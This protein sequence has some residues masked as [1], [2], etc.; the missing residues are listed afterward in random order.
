MVHL[1]R[2]MANELL[3]L[4]IYFESTLQLRDPGQ[5]ECV[6]DFLIRDMLVP[7]KESLA[8]AK[9]GLWAMVSTAAVREE[10]LPQL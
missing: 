7:Y 1:C 6:M 10:I 5:N 3:L 4:K 8:V 9:L 2:L